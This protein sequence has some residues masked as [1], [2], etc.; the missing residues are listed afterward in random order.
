[1]TGAGPIAARAPAASHRKTSRELLDAINRP[2]AR[3]IETMAL[4]RL[5]TML[6]D[7]YVGRGSGERVLKGAIRPGDVERIEAAILVTDMRGFTAFSNAHPPEQVIARLNAVF[8]C[9]MPAVEAEGGEVLKLIG[10]GLLAIF[11]L[12][13]SD[14]SDVCAAALRAAQ[15]A[16]IALAALDL[17]LR[18]ALRDGAASGRGQLRQYRCRRPARL[19]R[20]RAG[21]QL[22]R[23][24]RIPSLPAWAVPS[25]CRPD[26]LIWWR[27]R[28]SC[29]AASTCA[30]FPR[31]CR[32]TGWQHEPGQPRD[33]PRRRGWLAA[34]PLGQGSASRAWASPICRSCAAPASSGSTA[35]GS[36][37]ASAW[38]RVS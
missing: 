3:I 21:R 7:T 37:P 9:I 26:S 6:L 25:F 27:P 8:G 2:F 10:D 18:R 12:A 20:D 1:M 36:R 13:G 14:A 31:R 16:D 24:A 22:G 15:T 17:E 30:V 28:R 11:P 29:W 5:C 38:R 32:Y 4:H 35:S 23:P 19:H 33:G 34:R